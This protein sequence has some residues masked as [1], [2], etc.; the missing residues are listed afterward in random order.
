MLALALL[1]PLQGTQLVPS[2]LHAAKEFGTSVAIDGSTLVVGSVRDMPDAQF[3]HGSAYVFDLDTGQELF[4]LL[5]DVIGPSMDAFGQAVDVSGTVAV[6]GASRGQDLGTNAGA[7][8][9]FDVTTGNELRKLLPADGVANDRFGFSVAIEGSLVLVGSYLDDDL[10]AG[11]GSAYLF[12]ASTGAQL[13]KFVASDGAGGDNFGQA[14]ALAGGLAL[15]GAPGDD[16]LGGGSGAVYVFDTFS[17]AE[18]R[19]LVPNDGNAGAAFGRAVTASGDLALIGAHTDDDNGAASGSA[20]L[21]TPSTGQ[22]RLKLLPDD[23][24][25][26]DRFG[27]AVGLGGGV[28]LVGAWRDLGD[29]PGVEEGSAYFFDASSGAQLSK[30]SNFGPPR[31]ERFGYAVAVGGTWSAVGAPME[32]VNLESTAGAVW[33]Y[34]TRSVVGVPLG[35]GLALGVQ[36]LVLAMAGAWCARRRRV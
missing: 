8:Y 29:S 17:G 26:N 25:A 24:A 23:G 14:V 12:E 21:F 19:K 6:V 31:A 7:A 1:L 9:L 2:D 27:W 5:P 16:D 11:S 22:Q 28:A 35:S 10:G 18:L 15:V 4:E 13:H 33:R 32:S 30:V 34:A 3:D 20:Y 36:G